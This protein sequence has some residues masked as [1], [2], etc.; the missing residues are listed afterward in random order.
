[1]LI[2]APLPEPS[3][4]ACS[5][6][7]ADI[8]AIDAMPSPRVLV[9][10]SAHVGRNLFC[11]PALALIR[12]RWPQARVQALVGSRR[13]A[14]AL[15]GNPYVDE[16]RIGRGA[17]SVRREASRADL[18]LGLCQRDVAGVA[19]RLPIP[20]VWF[21]APSA[22]EHRA[23]ELLGFVGG[24]LGVPVTEEDRHYVLNPGPEDHRRA[25]RLLPK[26]DGWRWI[27]LHL[28]SGR[29]HAHGWKFWFRGRDDDRRLWGVERYVE[30]AHL[31]LDTD[32]RTRFV[33]TGSSAERFLAKRF[34]QRIPNAVD[35]VGRTSLLELA[36][37]M[38]RLNAFATQDTGPLH[39]AAA[40]GTPL[41]ALFGP[42]DPARTGPYPSRPHQ[43]VIRAL[44]TA[45]I[46]AP[47]VAEAL[48]RVLLQR[49]AA[50]G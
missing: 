16:I 46:E 47:T 23:D 26:P 31:L 8:A 15:E 9:V 14:A 29:T 13:G 35:L 39:V 7:A 1:M 12:R 36:A 49:L 43:R 28:G 33:L 48:E 21:Q 6:R 19:A 50:C 44:T 3:T 24:A 42:T 40:M 41:V 22:G 17:R 38:T 4:G 32:P 34:S 30:L 5:E 25:A 45:E 27:G 37:V 18:V 10:L 11:T 20:T 2:P